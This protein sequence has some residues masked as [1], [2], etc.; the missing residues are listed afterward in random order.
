MGSTRR[1]E[2]VGD[3][4]AMVREV[5]GRDGYTAPAA[6]GLGLATVSD[7]GSG[8]IAKFLDTD[9]LVTNLGENTG[10]A[11]AIAEVTGAFAGTTVLD[12]DRIGAI[13]ERFTPFLDD[14]G[15]H[16]NLAALQD[17]ARWSSLDERSPVAGH[18]R[19]AVVVVAPALDAAP[20]DAPDVYLRLTLLSQ[21]KVSPHGIS[22]D[23]AFGKL[24]NVVWTDLGPIDPDRFESVRAEARLAGRRLHVH[25]VDK[26]PRMLDYVV[27]AGVR[28]G[29]G[30]R[31]RLGAHLGDGTTVM[32]E[33]FVN[34]NAGTV[35]PNMVEGRISAGVVVAADSDLGGGCSTMGTLSGG[36]TAIVSVGARCLI[37][38]NAGIGISLGDDCTVEAGLYITAGTPVLVCGLAGFDDGAT[39]KARDLSGRDGLLIR[40]NGSTGTV[41]VHPNGAQWSGLNEALH[42]N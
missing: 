19:V 5:E 29:D 11:A 32:H 35:G 30:S 36:G 15:R 13:L 41:E 7:D 16:P 33:G 9:F 28:I 20:L 37:G 1:I 26:F 31:V 14:G 23:G 8:G 2:T 40:R 18:R 10:S 21:R 6:F 17:L 39:V 24:N 12:T 25:S 4:E 42:Q 34:F 3:F 38:A 22:L 27:P